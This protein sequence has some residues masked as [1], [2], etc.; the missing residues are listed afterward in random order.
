MQNRYAY[1]PF[2]FQL[3]KRG[4]GVDI[5]LGRK[6]DPSFV[7]IKHGTYLFDKCFEGY[8]GLAQ[9]TQC[10]KVSRQ[11]VV[12]DRSSMKIGGN[13]CLRTADRLTELNQDQDLKDMVQT[14]DGLKL[15]IILRSLFAITRVQVPLRRLEVQWEWRDHTYPR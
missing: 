14:D 1:K 15:A 8:A 7:G 12:S 13:H 5:R 11:R 9:D 2:G 4:V 3:E 6:L 10:L